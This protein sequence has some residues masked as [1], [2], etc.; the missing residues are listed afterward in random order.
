MQL[1]YFD[2]N[3]VYNYVLASKNMGHH[4]IDDVKNWPCNVCL[5]SQVEPEQLILAAVD[6][7]MCKQTFLLNNE[8]V[9]S[10]LLW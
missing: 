3:T 2:K 10:L 9:L 7:F 8:V 6:E 4:N 1:L 5:R